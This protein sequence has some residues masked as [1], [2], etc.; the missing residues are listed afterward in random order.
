[1]YFLVTFDRPVWYLQGHRKGER[2]TAQIPVAGAPSE[3]AALAHAL[4]VTSGEGTVIRIEQVEKFLGPP[5]LAEVINDRLVFIDARDQGP[6][7]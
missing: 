6:E 4:R 5:P 2:L 7:V 3:Q 1:M